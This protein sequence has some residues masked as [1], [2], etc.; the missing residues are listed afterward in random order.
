MNNEMYE[1]IK[2]SDK[3]NLNRVFL[4]SREFINFVEEART[5]KDELCISELV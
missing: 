2:N 3:Y 4:N 5:K 1:I